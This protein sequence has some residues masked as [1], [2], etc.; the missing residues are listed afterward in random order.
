MIGINKYQVD[1]DHEIEVL[2]V[3]QPGARRADRQPQQ[4]RA[5]RDQAAVDAAL[6]EL[7]VPPV[8]VAAGAA[9]PRAPGG[10][11]TAT[12]ARTRAKATV[13]RDSDALERVLGT[14]CGRDPYHRRG[15]PRRSRGRPNIAPP[16]S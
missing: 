3:E 13:G 15:L 11:P 12:A 8:R 5:D 7:T 16:P 1:E 14:A 9:K 2:K 6:A 4:L 10:P